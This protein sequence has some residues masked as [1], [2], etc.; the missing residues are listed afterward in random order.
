[1]RLGIQREKTVKHW[2]RAWKERLINTQN[3]D[4]KDLY[5]TLM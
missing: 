3:Q 2:L 1:M 4:W 5:D